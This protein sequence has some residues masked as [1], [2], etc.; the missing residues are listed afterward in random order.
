MR[1]TTGAVRKPAEEASLT[2]FLPDHNPNTSN[3]GKKHTLSCND[4]NAQTPFSLLAV[5]VIYGRRRSS[6]CVFAQKVEEALIY[7]ICSGF[8]TRVKLIFLC[9]DRWKKF[10][11]CWLLGRAARWEMRRKIVGRLQMTAGKIFLCGTGQRGWPRSQFSLARNM[12]GLKIEYQ[13][14]SEKCF[15]KLLG[16]YESS[17]LGVTF[18]HVHTVFN[19]L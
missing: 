4:K 8:M 6:P 12:A 18:H 19:A 9:L 13:S 7:L 17:F 2:E 11:Y 5:C 15:R 14:F 1:E 16:K 10:Q 3:A